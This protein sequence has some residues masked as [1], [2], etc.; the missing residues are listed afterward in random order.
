M[1]II[2]HINN[3]RTIKQQKEGGVYVQPFID[4]FF[5]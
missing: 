5:A 4:L 1:N 2:Y 3:K